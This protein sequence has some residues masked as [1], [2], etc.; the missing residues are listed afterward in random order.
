MQNTDYSFSYF[1]SNSVERGRA[2]FVIEAGVNQENK[3][4]KKEHN[5]RSFKLILQNMTGQFF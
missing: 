3:V 1:L 5:L 2:Y 4:E